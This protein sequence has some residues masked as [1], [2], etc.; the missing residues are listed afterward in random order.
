MASRPRTA[1]IALVAL[2][3]FA[4]CSARTN[5]SETNAVGDELITVGSFDFAESELLAEV[6]SQAM[7]S[8][9]YAV[10]RA[11]NLGPREFV[12]PAL[13]SGLVEF[14]PDY[15]GTVLQFARL[16]A[17]ASSADIAETHRALA[18]AVNARAITALRSAPAEDANVFVV[19]RGL[20]SATASAG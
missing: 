4:A 5:H 15:A 3:A 6:Y 12:A 16:G 11:F 9:G 20:H 8:R 1:R 19:R 17:D 14:V 18:V 10:H 2:L 7:E 13:A